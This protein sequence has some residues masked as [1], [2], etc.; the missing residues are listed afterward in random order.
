MLENSLRSSFPFDTSLQQEPIYSNFEVTAAHSHT[1][2]AP[3]PHPAS[4]PPRRLVSN[5]VI[6]GFPSPEPDG[7]AIAV[8]TRPL[9]GLQGLQGRHISPRNSISFQSPNRRLTSWQRT[10]LDPSQSLRNS[11]PDLNTLQTLRG[12]SYDE[13]AHHAHRRSSSPDTP[14][15]AAAEKAT[16]GAAAPTQGEMLGLPPLDSRDSSPPAGLNSASR[17]RIQCAPGDYLLFS[18]V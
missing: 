10:A 5:I 16:A 7:T 14:T 1:E 15:A 9:Q 18:P 12:P 13:H 6:G 4:I 8:G 17:N 11:S 3:S 2:P